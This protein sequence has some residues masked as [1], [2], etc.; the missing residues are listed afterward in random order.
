MPRLGGNGSTGIWGHVSSASRGRAGRSACLPRRT[1]TEGNARPSRSPVSSFPS[2]VAARSTPAAWAPR[3]RRSC[4][5]AEMISPTS[6]PRAPTPASE[7]I[8]SASPTPSPRGPS[9]AAL[10]EAAWRG[11][12]LRSPEA[13]L[14]LPYVAAGETP[15][16]SFLYC[17][18]CWT[19]TLAPSEP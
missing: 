1:K 15:S 6:H 8:A 9:A 12:K 13:G 17:F 4:E 10:R 3:R 5:L 2:P 7:S 14:P 11:E 18:S 16:F 19:H